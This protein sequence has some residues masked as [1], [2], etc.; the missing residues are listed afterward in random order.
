MRHDFYFYR[1]RGAELLTAST[2]DQ[3]VKVDKNGDC[4]M[5][6]AV[7]A[8][9][10]CGPSSNYASWPYD[11]RACTFSLASWV[12][13]G[14]EVAFTVSGDSTLV[15]SHIC[16]IINMQTFFFY[17]DFS[18]LASVPNDDLTSY[19]KKAKWNFVCNTTVLFDMS[20]GP[21][22]QLITACDV[23]KLR[24]HLMELNQ[25]SPRKS[26]G[27]LEDMSSTFCR[28]QTVGGSSKLSRANLD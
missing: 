7:T 13:D 3:V 27:I 14:H 12:H 28:W 16:T 18:F 9:V 15:L 5:N 23:Q 4:F 2:S 21:G 19:L 25:V 20:I 6:I 22:V 1:K 17:L 26:W 24:K 11:S 8:S 10:P